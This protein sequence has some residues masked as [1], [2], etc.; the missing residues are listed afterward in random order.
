MRDATI[1]DCA[2]P[3]IACVA[4][5]GR[6][7][8]PVWLEDAEMELWRVCAA[9]SALPMVFAAVE[10]G[11]VRYRDGGTADNMPA[12]ALRRF[13]LPVVGVEL[14]FLH[15]PAGGRQHWEEQLAGV[16]GVVPRHDDLGDM[17]LQPNVARFSPQS[18][19]QFDALVAAGRK[20]VGEALT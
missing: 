15:G 18:F 12:A 20:C 11:G 6:P 7:T 13:G 9:S 19:G 1:G 8:E 16:F 10:V 14:G 5:V 2:I 17:L 4:A 3:F